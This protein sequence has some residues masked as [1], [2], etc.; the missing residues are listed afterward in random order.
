MKSNN[1]SKGS[2][3]MY[4]DYDNLVPKKEANKLRL[5]IANCRG[6]KPVIRDIK[7]ARDII[8]GLMIEINPCK[9]KT[10]LKKVDSILWDLLHQ[11]D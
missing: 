7:K 1:Y 3:S 2:N 6:R 4:A 5:V 8:A 10:E 9:G 11:N